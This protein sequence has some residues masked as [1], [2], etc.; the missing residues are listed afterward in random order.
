M[1]L[2]NIVWN[3]VYISHQWI[4]KNCCYLLFLFGKTLIISTESTKHW[5]P[6]QLR[7]I[8]FGLNR[9]TSVRFS[10]MY[11]KR[12]KRKCSETAQAITGWNRVKLKR[13]STKCVNCTARHWSRANVAS[14]SFRTIFRERVAGSLLLNC[15]LRAVQCIAIITYLHIHKNR[16]GISVSLLNFYFTLYNIVLGFFRQ[17]FHN[18]WPVSWVDCLFTVRTSKYVPSSVYIASVPPWPGTQLQQRI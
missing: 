12:A 14:T 7:Q 9:E 5:K 17:Y 3:C 2:Q 4:T 15:C 8:W 10:F 18:I 1:S 16:A 13:Y 11:K 6:I